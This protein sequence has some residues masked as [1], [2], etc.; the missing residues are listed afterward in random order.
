MIKQSDETHTRRRTTKRET[1][2]S[3]A[4]ATMTGHKP[5]RCVPRS[6]HKCVRVTD[7]K[8]D[9]ERKQN[10]VQNTQNQH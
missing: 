8:I 2:S 9:T 3:S 1:H 10:K 4:A 7:A 5:N 6:M